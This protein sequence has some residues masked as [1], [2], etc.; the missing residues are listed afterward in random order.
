MTASS[1]HGNAVPT[2]LQTAREHA[3]TCTAQA[4]S[5]CIRRS[6]QVTGHV[7]V[8]PDPTSRLVRQMVHVEPL[9]GEHRLIAAGTRASDPRIGH[10]DHF[11]QPL[12]SVPVPHSAI[13]DSET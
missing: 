10:Q 5:A 2:G 3:L 1:A 7:D 13:L 6:T 4:A 9:T 11:S 12:V 8:I